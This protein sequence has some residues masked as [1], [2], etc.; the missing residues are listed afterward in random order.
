V[1]LIGEGKK[2]Q[3]YYLYENDTK[4]VQVFLF[5]H[6]QLPLDLSLFRVVDVI[7]LC[8]MPYK[9]FPSLALARWVP[10]HKHPTQGWEP[11]YIIINTH[12]GFLP[13]LIGTWLTYHY[14]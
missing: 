1:P 6:S 14:V 4:V 3:Y 2:M 12:E 10:T 13:L 11:A 5:T 7:A 9:W 8:P